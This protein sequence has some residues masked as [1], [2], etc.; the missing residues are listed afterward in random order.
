[1]NQGVKR[2][3]GAGPAHVKR[4]KPRSLYRMMEVV[5]QERTA[6]KPKSSQCMAGCAPAGDRW[7]EE[8]IGIV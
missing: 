8:G 2:V 5:Q 4:P 1:M 3:S 7:V 6:G